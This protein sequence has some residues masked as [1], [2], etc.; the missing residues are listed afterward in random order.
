MKYQ[1]LFS[2]KIR[3]SVII[4]S[5]AELARRMVEV[6]KRGLSR[7]KDSLRLTALPL[8]GNTLNSL[9][10]LLFQMLIT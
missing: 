10:Y 5:P 3:K 7:K 9:F 4:F 8:I 6:N 2:R 1:I